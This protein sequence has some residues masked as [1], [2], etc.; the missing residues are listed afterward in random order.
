MLVE[1]LL[2]LVESGLGLYGIAQWSLSLSRML[3]RR[4]VSDLVWCTVQLYS[5]LFI[6]CGL[7]PNPKILLLY[8]VWY[9]GPKI[10][11]AHA[12]KTT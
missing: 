1:S 4:L 10:L 5:F 8:C 12:S 3:S 9:S 7:R 2:V 11:S 6:A